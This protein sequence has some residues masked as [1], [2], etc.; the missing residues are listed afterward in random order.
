LFDEGFYFIGLH[1]PLNTFNADTFKLS[2]HKNATFLYGN[3][4]HISSQ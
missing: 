4:Q 1:Q 2:W 3:S